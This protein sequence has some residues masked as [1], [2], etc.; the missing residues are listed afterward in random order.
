M[1][2]INTSIFSFINENN[3]QHLIEVTPNKYVY[4]TS[5]P[6]FRDK[7]SKMGLMPK[8]KSDAWLSNTKIDGKVIFA[9]NSDIKDD[10][11]NSGYDDDLYRIDTTKLNNKWY[12]DPNFLGGINKDITTDRII[13]F[14]PIPKES[15]E[16]IYKGTGHNLDESIKVLLVSES[17][18]VSNP[19]TNDY[20]EIFV[21][22]DKVGY[23]I[24]APARDEYYWVYINLPKPLAIVDVKIYTE[25][26]GKNYMKYTMEWLYNFAKKNGYDSLFLRVDDTSEIP[27]D[28]LIDIYKKFGFVFYKTN[29]DDDDIYMYKLL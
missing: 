7:I 17:I 27:Q 3:N 19:Q 28:T 11:W 14:D 18:K 12:Y 5:N 9:V 15:I 23:I 21:G 29:D 1:K 26:R 16:L 22:D 24:L 13:T 10:W 20:N 25:F 6:I 2:Y 8:G 4:H